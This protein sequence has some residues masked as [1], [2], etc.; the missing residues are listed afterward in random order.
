MHPDWQVGDDSRPTDKVLMCVVL[1]PRFAPSLGVALTNRSCD[2][3]KITKQ[4]HV[5]IQ[6]KLDIR[7]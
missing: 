7:V 1:T 5:H 2:S 3:L 6:F 4:I